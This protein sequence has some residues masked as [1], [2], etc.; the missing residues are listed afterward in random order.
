MLLIPTDELVHVP[1][2]QFSP[3][4][5]PCGIA[6]VIFAPGMQQGSM[7][8][9]QE[10]PG[11]TRLVDV[12]QRASPAGQVVNAEAENGIEEKPVIFPV[13]GDRIRNPDCT[14][15]VTATIPKAMPI[16]SLARDR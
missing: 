13:S 5:H 16:T 7:G 3:S 9:G 14:K 15:T 12:P 1:A 11:P 8:P 6:V 4:A 10:P 2:M